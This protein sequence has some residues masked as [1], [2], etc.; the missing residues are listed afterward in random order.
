MASESEIVE[1]HSENEILK[2]S[3]RCPNCP[4]LVLAEKSANLFEKVQNLPHFEKD[5]DAEK[6]QFWWKVDDM[7]KF[8]NIGFRIR[9]ANCQQKNVS[10]IVLTNFFGVF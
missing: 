10:Q 5:K 9:I 2:C 6:I 7:Y 3:V 1:K 8:E 4:S